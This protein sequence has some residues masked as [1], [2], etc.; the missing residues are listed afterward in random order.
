MGL[1]K[2]HLLDSYIHAQESGDNRKCK[3]ILHIIRHEEQKSN[4]PW[5][6]DDVMATI[7]DKIIHL[8]GLLREG[9]DIIDIMADHFRYY[10]G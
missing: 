1:W 10:W 8:F 6:V 4:I 2:V 7:L 5:D 9:H 3:D